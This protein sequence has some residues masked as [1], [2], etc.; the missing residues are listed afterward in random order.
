V[1]INPRTTANDLMKMLEETSTQVSIAIVK[2]V[3]YRHNL[4]GRTAR[5]KSLLQ[6][7]HKKAILRFAT[8]HGDKDCT[9]GA[10]SSGLRKQK[11]NFLTIMTI[12][13]RLFSL[14]Q[15]ATGTSCNKHSNWTV[16]TQFLHSKTQSWTLLLTVV[17]ANV[18]C[19]VVSTFFELCAVVC[20]Q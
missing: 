20:A 12:V 18:W 8:A 6:N 10:M 16:L 19:I 3:L 17:A 15:L 14:L 5:K 2:R 1:Q 4:K 7:L 9:S 13:T 11:Y